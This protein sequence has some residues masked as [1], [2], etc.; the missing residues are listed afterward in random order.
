MS[1]KIGVKAFILQKDES[2]YSCQDRIGIKTSVGRFVV[3]DGVTNSYHPEIVAR[4]LCQT[5]LEGDFSSKSWIEFF[6]KQAFGGI[7]QLWKERV[8]KIES[9][10]SEW[11]LEL[12]GKRKRYPFGAST[13]AGIDVD[14]IEGLIHYHIIGDSCLF[15]IDKEEKSM[16]CFSTSKS[17]IRDGYQYYII[18]NNPQCIVSDLSLAGSFDWLEGSAPIKKGY[19][20]LMTDGSAKWFQDEMLKDPNT[21]SML[22]NIKNHKDF[23]NLVEAQRALGLMDDD[24][25]IILLKIENKWNQ[26]FAPLFIDTWQGYLPEL[27]Q[28]EMHDDPGP[29][30]MVGWEQYDLSLIDEFIE[31]MD[32]FDRIR[33]N[34][35]IGVVNKKKSLSLVRKCFG[36]V[37]NKLEK[38]VCNIWT[39]L[40]R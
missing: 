34:E 21:I 9:S 36:K 29:K 15:L 26:G 27:I 1:D 16:H 12:V 39:Y 22:W 17:E 6:K 19:A 32:C 3:A 18:G 20:I 4:S 11:D 33:T 28:F 30:R 25:S 10:L 24:I 2:P 35:K 8:K 7:C 14:L 31:Q 40:K 13:F 5:F 23:T 38:V 37:C